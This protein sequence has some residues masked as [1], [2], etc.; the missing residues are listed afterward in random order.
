MRVTQRGMDKSILRI[1]L[2]DRK[3][4]YE[5]KQKKKVEDIVHQRITKQK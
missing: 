5:M 4:N 3:R 1:T 2:E